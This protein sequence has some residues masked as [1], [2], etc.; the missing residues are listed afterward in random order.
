MDSLPRISR[1]SLSMRMISVHSSSS[2]RLWESSVRA[3]RLPDLSYSTGLPVS[4]MGHVVPQHTG[5]QVVFCRGFWLT[6]LWGPSMEIV[7]PLFLN[8]YD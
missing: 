6:V 4:D 8:A 5:F 1:L 7:S 3:H 2:W